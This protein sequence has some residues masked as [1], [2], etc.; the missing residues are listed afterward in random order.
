M[1]ENRSLE[2]ARRLA[3]ITDR[4]VRIPFTRFEFGLDAIFGLI[5]GAGDAAGALLSASVVVIGVKAGVPGATLVR[6]LGNVAVDTLVGTVP[7]LGDVFDA[8]WKA[9]VRNVALIDAHLVAPDKGRRASALVVGGT[10]LGLV[11]TAG[12]AVWSA[13]WIVVWFI[14]VAVALG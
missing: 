9:N 2:I 6:M 4:A 13:L 3:H 10:I 5:P 12:F 7:V 11:A 1:T 14:D 8:A